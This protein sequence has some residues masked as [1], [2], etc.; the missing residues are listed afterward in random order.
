[1]TPALCPRFPLIRIRIDR[2]RGVFKQANIGHLGSPPAS[3]KYPNPTGLLSKPIPR[4][5]SLHD[6]KTAHRLLPFHVGPRYCLP[7]SKVKWVYIRDRNGRYLSVRSGPTHGTVNFREGDADISSAFQAVLSGSRYGF[8][9][10]NGK[11]IL[12]Y[13][14]GWISCDG[15]NSGT[16]YQLITANG[17]YIYLKDQASNACFPSSDLDGQGSPICYSYIKE[18]SRFEIVQ[19]AI[20]NEIFDVNYDISGAQI[21][22]TAPTQ[23]ICSQRLRWRGQPNS[24]VLVREVQG[25]HLE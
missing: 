11:Y 24:H 22:D 13:Y 17:N 12:R 6:P 3:L 23:Y 1:M 15:L 4:P 18:S 14:N 9:G 10:S 2:I 5:L 21:C 16:W 7:T 25:W 8:Q 20:K 19:A